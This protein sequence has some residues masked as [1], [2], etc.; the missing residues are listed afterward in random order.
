MPSNID[1]INLSIDFIDLERERRWSS[2]PRNLEK[3][4]LV[5]LNREREQILVAMELRNR[6]KAS[7][8]PVQMELQCVYKG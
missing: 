7:K 2:L 8:S 3:W 4:S 5:D 1:F 6:S